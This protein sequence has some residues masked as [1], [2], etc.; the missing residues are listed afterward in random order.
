MKE[1]PPIILSVVQAGTP[2]HPRFKVADQSMR[3]WTG[4]LWSEPNEE[5]QG[6]LYANSIDACIETQWLLILEYMDKKHKRF[7]ATM[8]LDLFCDENV[9]RDKLIRWLVRVSKLFLNNDEHGNGPLEGS[10]GLCRIEWGEL[11]EVKDC[12]RS[13]M[14]MLCP[15]CQSRMPAGA[16]VCPHYTRSIEDWNRQIEEQAK[17]WPQPPAH[18]LPCN[19][20]GAFVP[21]DLF[22]DSR[23]GGRPGRCPACNCSLDTAFWD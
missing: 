6:L 12:R 5:H 2:E 20:C 17:P 11:Q 3:Y 4:E 7:K 9:P 10:L 8:Y 22:G 23:K 1:R 16:S 21:E 14:G 13:V 19:G 18:T 15:W